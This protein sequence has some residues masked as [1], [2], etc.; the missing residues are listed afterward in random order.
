LGH[1]VH[2]RKESRDIEQVIAL[3]TKAAMRGITI[4]QNKLWVGLIVEKANHKGD[5]INVVD[6]VC[7]ALKVGVG[8]DDRWFCIDFLDWRINKNNPEIFIQL[9]QES[10]ESL[11]ACSHCGRLLPFSAFGKHKGNHNDLSRA[12]K[13]CRS[14][15]NTIVKRTGAAA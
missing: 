11:Q 9:G 5:G 2:K 3:A 1:H 7:D 15:A 14:L 12:C 4:A 13:E 8:L 10:A 6:L